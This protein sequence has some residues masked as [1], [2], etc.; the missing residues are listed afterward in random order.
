MVPGF[1]EQFGNFLVTWLVADLFHSR[2]GWHVWQL[3][4][5]RACV[6][7][8][9]QAADHRVSVHDSQ[10]PANEYSLPP[11]NTYSGK[12]E[13]FRGAAKMGFSAWR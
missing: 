11:S 4:Q 1:D 8:P 3:W 13:D 9:G 12:A 5:A 7:D 6:E 2:R 10:G